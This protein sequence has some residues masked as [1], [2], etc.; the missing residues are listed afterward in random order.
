[1]QMDLRALNSSTHLVFL[2]PCIADL[3]RLVETS[4]CNDIDLVHTY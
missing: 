1:M 2:L 3:D 4:I